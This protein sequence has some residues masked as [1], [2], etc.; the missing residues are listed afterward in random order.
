MDEKSKLP[1]AR[2]RFVFHVRT[3]PLVDLALDQPVRFQFLQLRRQHGLRYVGY[4]ASQLGNAVVAL[5]EKPENLKLPP[6]R[7]H[8]KGLAEICQPTMR[9]TLVVQ[10]PVIHSRPVEF[11][12]SGPSAIALGLCGVVEQ[13]PGFIFLKASSS[14]SRASTSAGVG[15]RRWPFTMGP[16]TNRCQ[17]VHGAGVTLARA[18]ILGADTTSRAMANAASRGLVIASPEEATFWLA[19]QLQDRISIPFIPK[20]LA[21]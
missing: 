6:T 21:G 17:I 8:A 19:S 7:E 9:S 2:G 5:V 18:I 14:R 1:C 16:G 11:G 12:S 20:N 3:E 10:V 13:A 4:R 15:W